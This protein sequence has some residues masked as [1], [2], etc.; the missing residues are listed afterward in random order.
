[1]YFQKTDPSIITQCPSLSLTTFSVLSMV[2][3]IFPA[4]GTWITGESFMQ[5]LWPTFWSSQTLLL[6]LHPA[7]AG[8]HQRMCI[9]GSFIQRMIYQVWQ[10]T[11]LYTHW[12]RVRG[13]K[14]A[15]VPTDMAALR[16]VTGMLPCTCPGLAGQRGCR[17]NELF[18]CFHTRL[19]HTE[20]GQSQ[21]GLRHKH[22]EQ[23]YPD[24][25]DNRQ[26]KQQG[27]TSVHQAPHLHQATRPRLEEQ[28]STHTTLPHLETTSSGQVT[29]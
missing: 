22:A 16:R 26:L 7:E 25:A 9:S 14:N 27:T 3:Y 18:L 23:P 2:V 4:Y 29:H 17:A 15:E 19:P 21:Q 24:P 28:G 13:Q 12:E 1:M 11:A 10:G 8:D 20:K 6:E 5:V